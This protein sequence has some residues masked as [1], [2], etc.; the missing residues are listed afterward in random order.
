MSSKKVFSASNWKYFPV[1]AKMITFSRAG[2]QKNLSLNDTSALTVIP[3]N[4]LEENCKWYCLEKQKK[5]VVH[6]TVLIYG[7]KV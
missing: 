2:I 4:T 5:R 6:L 3:K 7:M 1:E